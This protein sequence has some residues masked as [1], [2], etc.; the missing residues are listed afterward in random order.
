[1]R[2]FKGM[3][4][5]RGRNRAGGGGKPGGG[6]GGNANRAFDSNGPEHLKVRGSAQHIYEKYVQLARDAGAGDRVLL[7]N[8][9]QHA[10][11]YYRLIRTL[12]PQRPPADIMGRDTFTNGYDI[13]FEDEA[14]E[15][16]Q[17]ASEAA[18]E[19]AAAAGEDMSSPP[20]S[21]DGQGFREREPRRD[22][23]P[24]RDRDDRPRDDRPRDERPRDDRPRDDRPRDDRPRDDRP[25]EG[26]REF[27]DRDDRPREGREFRDREGRTD[28]P[29]GRGDFGGQPRADRPE[30]GP[31][32]E[33]F[34]RDRDR[35]RP[36]EG[37]FGERGESRFGERPREDG[38]RDG[39]PADAASE[40]AGMPV[41]DDGRMLRDEE[42]GL[43]PAPAFLQS[44]TPVQRDD[45]AGD[46]E[47]RPRRRRRTREPE[48]SAE[49]APPPA[50][51]DS[52]EA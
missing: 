20:Q 5:Q 36:R 33:R 23:R 40:P 10:E 12:Q 34:E 17:A 6:G 11:H 47:P 32:P 25:R 1:M 29:D 43:S 45:S 8:Y 15:A 48:A 21:Q 16:Q 27:R 14:I 18:G 28:R 35:D 39:A 46:E 44:A 31:R 24:Y 42:G 7:E 37:R 22:D 51:S 19:A 3:K 41:E 38:G 2:D 52:E 50:A 30:R 26:A 13:D 49:D 9:L 4:R